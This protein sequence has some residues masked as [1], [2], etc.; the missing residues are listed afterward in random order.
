[1]L[2][3]GEYGIQ[4]SKAMDTVLIKQE[5]IRSIE[6]IGA[7]NNK[8]NY[9]DRILSLFESQAGSI[10]SQVE[11]ALF[12]CDTKRVLQLAHTLKGSALCIGAMKLAENCADLEDFIRSEGKNEFSYT[13][14]NQICPSMDMLAEKI[15]STRIVYQQTIDEL[16][17]FIS[18]NHS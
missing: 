14:N 15:A 18:K 17:P 2:V 7:K 3:K 6:F 4:R 1:M 8:S 11:D 9:L 12:H 10:L 13:S 5:T 16:R